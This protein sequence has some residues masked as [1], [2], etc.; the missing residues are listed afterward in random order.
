MMSND[1]YEDHSIQLDAAEDLA[2]RAIRNYGTADDGYKQ[3][4]CLALQSIAQSLAVLTRLMLEKV[5]DE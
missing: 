2:A 3:T 5:G 1:R 4:N